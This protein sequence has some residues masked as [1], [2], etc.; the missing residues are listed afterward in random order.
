MSEE[1]IRLSCTLDKNG[2]P[3]AQARMT[4]TD[5]K[6]KCQIEIARRI[7]IMFVPGIMGSN[8]QYRNG[9]DDMADKAEANEK[10]EQA[11][12]KPFDGKQDVDANWEYLKDKEVEDSWMPPNSTM[13]QIDAI[14][15]DG[16]FRSVQERHKEIHHDLTSVSWEGDIDEIPKT[17]L[18]ITHSEKRRQ[19]I[20]KHGEIAHDR[21]LKQLQKYRLPDDPQVIAEKQRYAAWRKCWEE[22]K[23]SRKEQIKQ[24]LRFRGWGTVHASS[25]HKFLVFFGRKPAQSGRGRPRGFRPQ[26]LPIDRSG[27]HKLR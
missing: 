24:E 11:E 5:D 27:L 26:K 1:N 13:Q 23:P 2:N 22:N 3:T 16:F 4:V 18:K 6:Q 25:Y 17:C 14:F 9:W 10:S 7:P 8:L 21:K 15:T 12:A 19:D 20:L